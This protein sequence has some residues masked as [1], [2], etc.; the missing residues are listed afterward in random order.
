MNAP[1]DEIRIDS[2]A[3]CLLR[4]SVNI[5]TNGAVDHVHRTTRGGQMAHPVVGERIHRPPPRQKGKP[6]GGSYRDRMR[7]EGHN[8]TIHIICRFL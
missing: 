2:R 1:Q 8:I 4:N 7:E 3:Q 6:S 5:K